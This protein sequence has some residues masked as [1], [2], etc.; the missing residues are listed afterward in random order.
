MLEN[1]DA[2]VVHVLTMYITLKLIMLQKYVRYIHINNYI[3]IYL[4]IY[5]TWHVPCCLDLALHLY[6]ISKVYIL[7]V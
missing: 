6:F 4:S 2:L 3:Y 7:D 1:P 5:L